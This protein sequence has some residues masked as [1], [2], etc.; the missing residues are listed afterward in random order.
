MNRLRYKILLGFGILSL[1]ILLLCIVELV[2]IYQS[3]RDSKNILKDNYASI[4]YT[5][6]MQESLDNLFISNYNGH[7]EPEAA[8]VS[9]LKINYNNFRKE[10]SYYMDFQKK[11]ITET[12]EKELVAKLISN[13]QNFS[14]AYELMLSNKQFDTFLVKSY[15]H[16]RSTIQGIHDLNMQAIH[17]KNENYSSRAK[18]SSLYIGIMAVLCLLTAIGLLIY[19]PGKILTPITQLSSK[20]RSVANKDYDQFFRITPDAELAELMESFNTM[21]LQLKK[22]NDDYE[23]T[24]S[25]KSNQLE[26]L[27]DKMDDG[28]FLCDNSDKIILI[29]KYA[30]SITGIEKSMITGRNFIEAS[31]QYPIFRDILTYLFEKEINT[32]K[33]LRPV[34]IIINEKDEYFNI[35]KIYFPIVNPAN[36]TTNSYAIICR[37][38]TKYEERD[39]A[40]TNLIATVSHQLKTPVSSINLSLKLLD[41]TRVGILNA[42]QKQLITAIKNQTKKL[43]EYI[44][45]LLDFSQVETGE[46]KLNIEETDASTIVELASFA[47]MIQLSEKNIELEPEIPENLPRVKAD[48]EKTV[49]VLVNLLSNAVRYSNK[50]G[51]IIISLK[52][53]PNYIQFSVQDF[54]EGIAPDQQ[55]KVFDKFVKDNNNK[56]KGTGLGL[57]IAKEFIQSQKGSIWLESQP[58]KGTTFTFTIPSA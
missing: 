30:E 49:W 16:L 25:S 9:Y 26:T 54:G 56:L 15:E 52:S 53:I 4:D 2:F 7:L 45:E 24:L 10:F 40:K 34:K 5:L 11:N 28:I 33:L 20:L 21:L 37:N 27:I 22:Y 51:K 36:E 19:F 3:T 50:D 31:R 57:A 43:S 41:D 44:N 47:L 6:K 17:Y 32:Q 46:I 1:L 13:Y 38:I 39:L 48:L 12:G 18:D 42:E 23:Q 55:S 35:E 29:N 58:G 14:D 8:T